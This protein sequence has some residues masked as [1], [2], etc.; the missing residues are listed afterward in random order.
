MGEPWARGAIIAG[1]YPIPLVLAA[2]SVPTGPR[3]IDR[4]GDLLAEHCQRAWAATHRGGP[5]QALHRS[6]CS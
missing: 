3:L 1:A 2:D 4:A 6:L 5:G